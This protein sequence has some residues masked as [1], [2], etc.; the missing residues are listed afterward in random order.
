MRSSGSF[1]DGGQ[2]ACR[3]KPNS[4]VNGEQVMQIRKLY[5][6]GWTQGSLCREFQLSIGQIGK[7]VRGE[8]WTHLPTITTDR[9][10]QAAAQLNDLAEVRGREVP[11]EVI[12]ASQ[13]RVMELLE[14]G[15]K[16]DE[17]M[18]QIVMDRYNG[19]L[20]REEPQGRGMERLM[21]EAEKLKVIQIQPTTADPGQMLDELTGDSHEPRPRSESES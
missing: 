18:P 20:K 19:V 11:E 5:A 16:Q 7:I 17:A 10:Y 12:K 15:K 2:R 6:E 14:K 1:I 8:S 21:E 13:E 9:E 3:K 4:K